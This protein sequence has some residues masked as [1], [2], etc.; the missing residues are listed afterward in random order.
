MRSTGDGDGMGTG[1]GFEDQSV[2]VGR[3]LRG[4]GGKR[5][6]VFERE[7]SGGS[8]EVAGYGVHG[9][10]IGSGGATPAHDA[11]VLPSAHLGDGF[12]TGGYETYRD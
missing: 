2:P 10:G 6:S 5:H 7:G 8:C 3:A 1:V 12:G 11:K 9:G 4:D